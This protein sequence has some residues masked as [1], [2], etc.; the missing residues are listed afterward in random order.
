M[1]ISVKQEGWL[2]PGLLI[3]PPWGM[4]TIIYLNSPGHMIKMAAAPFCTIH[5]TFLYNCVWAI[6][7]KQLGL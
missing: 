3:K 6:T 2:R 4:G 5:H 7:S 1:Y